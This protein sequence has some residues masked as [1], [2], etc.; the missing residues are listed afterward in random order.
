M[1]SDTPGAPSPHH[2]APR[3]PEA[4]AAPGATPELTDE[5]LEFLNSLFDLARAGE[6]EALLSAV[7]QGVPVNLANHNGDTLLILATYNNHPALVRALLER[8]ADVHRL[9]ARG[10]SALACAVFVQNE[11]SV[12]A[13]LAA[14]A[15][16]D[17]GPVSARA[18]VE[19][20]GL[21]AMRRLLDE[22][23]R[24]Q[25]HGTVSQP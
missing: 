2:D 12:R 11:E 16:P 15:D 22:A 4:P 18:A 8:G 6:A 5:Q 3:S 14:G 10:Q 24:D 1:T 20:F 25:G 9:N 13:L 21:D 19:M 17:A 23:S 7:D